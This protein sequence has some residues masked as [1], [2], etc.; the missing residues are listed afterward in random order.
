MWR[1]APLAK[2]GL[3]GKQALGLSEQLFGGRLGVLKV[4][5]H[6]GH[7]QNGK[8]Q[9]HRRRNEEYQCIHGDVA[10]FEV[11]YNEVLTRSENVTVQLVI[12]SGDQNYDYASFGG[13]AAGVPEF[14]TV[15]LG[16][17][18]MGTIF[19]L[20]FLRKKKK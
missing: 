15:T 7:F 6:A 13:V 11:T 17:A 19:G 18:V 3:L 20:N 9:V 4:G 8:N 14:S 12:I 1:D 16:L 2:R 10:W 5:N